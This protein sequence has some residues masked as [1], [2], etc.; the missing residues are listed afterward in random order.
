MVRSRERLAETHPQITQIGANLR[1]LRMDLNLTL[2][3]PSH[4]VR[5]HGSSPKAFDREL[6]PQLK[7]FDS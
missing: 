1:N 6:H 3:G 7:E 5:I 4:T 2:P